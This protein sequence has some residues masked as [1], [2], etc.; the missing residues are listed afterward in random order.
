MVGANGAQNVLMGQHHRPGKAHVPQLRLAA[1]QQIRAGH[2]PGLLLSHNIR[3]KIGLG[4]VDDHIVQVK[5][6]CNP[7]GGENIV[8]P[9]GMEMG[10][11]LPVQY[12]H[13]RLQLHVKIRSVEV[14]ILLGQL[15][16]HPVLLGF[17]E[18][19]PD[20]CRRSHT[21]HRR[22]VPVVIRGLRIFSQGKLHGNGR[23]QNHVINAPSIG[24]DGRRLP[25]NGIG[26]TRSHDHRSHAAVPG[27][28]KGAVHGIDAVDH[29]QLRGNGIGGLVTVLGFKAHPVTEQA[30]MGVDIHKAG[31][32]PFAARIQDFFSGLG[33]IL[34]HRAHFLDGSA[35]PQ[36]AVRNG[37]SHHGFNVCMG[38]D[39]S[40]LLFHKNQRPED[41]LRPP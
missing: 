9:M 6:L 11:N 5:F 21:G 16:L 18:I 13:Q 40:I 31:Q 25:R 17:P 20:Q 28:L 38:D 32:Q 34:L 8:Q 30:Q 10:L 14:R 12:R 36:V 2:H 35:K 3:G 15:L 19:F 41:F 24:S 26:R 27:I 22:F 4:A 39:H 37:F 29:P 1:I 33:H 7:D 23:F